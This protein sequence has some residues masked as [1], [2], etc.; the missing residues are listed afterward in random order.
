MDVIDGVCCTRGRGGVIVSSASSV[1]SSNFLAAPAAA[2]ACKGN[3][4]ASDVS[5]KASASDISRVASYGEYLSTMDWKWTVV[6][7]IAGVS[8]VHL[9]R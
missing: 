5:L 2:P 1:I 8:I 6:R 9:N 7:A 3:A 4:A